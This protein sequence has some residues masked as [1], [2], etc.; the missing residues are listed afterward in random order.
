MLSAGMRVP[1]GDLA[2]AEFDAVETAVRYYEGTASPAEMIAA[3]RRVQALRVASAFA[4]TQA[5][6]GLGGWRPATPA[7]P[8]LGH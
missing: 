5:R 3:A 1:H 6:R 7:P 2:R 8:P 4:R